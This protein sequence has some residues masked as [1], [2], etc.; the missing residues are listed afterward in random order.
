MMESYNLDIRRTMHVSALER[1]TTIEALPG[2]TQSTSAE[3]AALLLEVSASDD[4][5]N[6]GGRAIDGNK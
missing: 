1:G 6:A 3:V 5:L 4:G 2:A